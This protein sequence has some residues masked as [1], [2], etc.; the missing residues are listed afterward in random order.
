MAKI[1]NVAV[2]KDHG[3]AGVTLALKNLSHGLVNNVLRS[4]ATPATNA[5][6]TFI[7]AVVALPQIREKVVLNILDGLTAV[8]QG[9]PSAHPNGMWAYRSLFFATDPVALD[10]VGWQIIDAKRAAMG[11]P[12]V[13]MAGRWGTPPNPREGFDIR[14]PQHI[15]LAM[16]LG[17]GLANAHE[18][19]RQKVTMA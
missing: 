16:A 7:P 15:P 14:Q 13:A 5:C 10:T 18:I 8:Y 19:Q 1:I 4:H 2:L 3:A 12:P 6:H 9:G 17:L 11:L